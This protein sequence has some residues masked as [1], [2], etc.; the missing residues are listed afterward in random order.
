MGFENELVVNVAVLIDLLMSL[1]E[2]YFL[3]GVQF[4]VDGWIFIKNKYYRGKFVSIHI[5]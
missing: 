2:G 5:E 1:E 3:F 4:L